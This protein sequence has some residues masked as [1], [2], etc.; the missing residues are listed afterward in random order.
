MT[1][2]ANALFDTTRER[3]RAEYREMPG[4]RLTLDQ[5]CRL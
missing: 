2:R 5:A 3:V 1:T 4:V